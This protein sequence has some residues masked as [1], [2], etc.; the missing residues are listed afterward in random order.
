MDTFMSY[1]ASDLKSVLEFIKKHSEFEDIFN[2]FHEQHKRG[3]Q[4]RD[5]YELIEDALKPFEEESEA[6]E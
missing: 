3:Y 2:K 6:Q 4:R 1:A 5:F